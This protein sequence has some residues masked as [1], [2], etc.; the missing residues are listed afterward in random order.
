MTVRTFAEKTENQ[1]EIVKNKNSIL[2]KVGKG[3]HQ[4][5]TALPPSSI[6]Y[7][8]LKPYRPRKDGRL[9]KPSN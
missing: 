3:K 6:A 9:S 5:R 2:V 1:A 8:C 4:L 7:I